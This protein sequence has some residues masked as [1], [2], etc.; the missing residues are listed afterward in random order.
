MPRREGT[1]LRYMPK[2]SRTLAKL[3]RPRLHGAANRERLFA[4]LDECRARKSAVCVVGPPGAG[5]TTVVAT[6][7]DARAIKGIW[8]QI[9][10]GD[11]DL[12]TFF[13][14]LGEAA[15]TFSGKKQ[16]PLP[17]LTPEYQHDIEG[18][19][20]RFFRTLFGLL[21]EGAAVVLDNYQEVEAGQLFHDLVA[22]AIAEI[23]PGIVLVAISRRDPPD[24]YA[25]LIANENV[26][27]V[28][29]DDLKLNI[30]EARTIIG[31]RLSG[32]EDIEAQ[33]LLDESGCWA[34]GLTL[35]LD[36]YRNRNGAPA[37][38]PAERESIFSY[39]A[40]QIF[41]RLPVATRH[42]L[43]STSVLAQVP[44]S[45][46]RDLTGNAHS[47]E[48][49]DD[50][51]KRHLFTHRRPGV[52][53]TY[54]YHALFRAFL[55]GKADAVLTTETLRE[56]E[57]KAARLLEARL[58]FDD[59]FQLF[60]DA[61][62]W[63]GARRL[64][65]RHA[66]T[67]LAHGRGQTL[68]DWALALPNEVLEE[69]PWLRY[70]LGTSL[71]PLEQRQA[72]GH[73]ERAFAQFAASGDATGQALSAAGLIDSYFFEWS[74][75]R[76]MRRWVDTLDPLLERMHFSGDPGNERKIYT[77]LLIGMLYAAPDH[78]LLPRTVDR[79]TEMLDEEM[80][81]NSKVS[82]AMTLLSYCNLACDMER[83]KVA[84][85]CADPLLDH[86][87]LTPF[88]QVWW[89]LRKGYYFQVI[90]QYLLG[91]D[92]LDRA[93]AISETHGLQ[94]LR[95]TFLLI[96]SFQIPCFTMLGDVRN[97]RKVHERMVAMA[98]SERPMDAYHVTNSKIHL[99][100]AADNYRGV[101]DGGRQAA[102]L[103]VAAGMRYIEIISVEHEVAGLAV[104]GEVDRLDDAL[105]RL[106]RLVSG[107][108]FG[109]F[110]CEARFVEV[111]A[112]LMHGDAERGRSLIRNAVAFARSHRFQYPQM[113]RYTVVTGTVMA[114][115]LRIGVEP[116][117]LCDLIRRLH[118]RP[119]AN[120]PETW[121]WL[122]KI[123]TLGG[124]EIKV[125]GEALEFPGKAPRRLLAVLKAIIAGGG[126][127]VPSARLVDAI[128]PNEEGDAGRKALEVCLVR[129]RKLLGQTDAVVVRDEQV[130][131]NRELCWVDAWA[132]ADMVEM[133]ESGGEN[134]KVLARLGNHA[135]DLYK[136]NLLPADE[137]DRTVI[138]A[139]LKLRDLFTRLVS[140]LGQ[141]MEASG[142][143]GQA[144]ACYR[145]GID[146]DELTEEFYQGLMRCHAA[147]GRL[148][149]GLAVYRRLRQ[150]LSVVLGL[151]PSTRTEQLVQL[152]RGESAGP[153]S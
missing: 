23:P 145:R 151:K 50:L 24:S 123:L 26:G 7:L 139:R 128:W 127:P 66:Q 92:A 69:A 132:F 49:L 136:G 116:D 100:C 6:W 55:R 47:S 62:D 78:R 119:P 118:I 19:S 130:S 93:K 2:H 43:V 137:E 31:A 12:A 22:L 67:L 16:R 138:M 121:P 60:H 106:R 71:V 39:F 103:A 9:D 144:L 108:C 105:S 28:D 48:I 52:E 70:W 44:V 82:L 51:Y 73:L 13:Y 95:R 96:A 152:L 10:S 84:V 80:D 114:E 135:L 46:A 65:E 122:V 142:N 3:T 32:I 4:R 111:Y 112:A 81:V 36:S 17:L 87:E 117:Y 149:E 25:R 88:N 146:A 61:G 97:A 8:F 150:T 124:F 90:G 11:A 38:L 1:H 29:W 148:A 42:F 20:R 79:V 30:E 53:P 143:W 14:Y 77:S 91:L 41:E 15:K 153:I 75:F 134:P 140:A 89:H 85:S 113:M 133:V 76:P 99:E 64:I 98:A 21:P 141:Q 83:A 131:L 120:A 126:E 59:A 34:A 57:R 86:P 101:V 45:L 107:S 56:T 68:R 147:T 110:E 104:L 63:A 37:G 125:D 54:W 94:G 5:K 33:R 35:M 109:F 40:T 18:F 58:D 72:R 129:L 27:I 102:E 115:A 74:D